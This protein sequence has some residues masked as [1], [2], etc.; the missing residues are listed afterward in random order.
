MPIRMTG[1]ISGLDTDAVVKELMSAQSLKKTKIEQKK[2]KAEWKQDKWKELNTKLYALY[3][4][5]VSK[6]KLKSSYMTKKVTSS[7]ENLVTATANTS[8][9]AGSHTIKVTELAS[10]QYLTGK[11]T[12]GLK[13]ATANT[14]LVSESLG[15]KSGTIITV[16]VGDKSSSMTVTE[17]STIA[18][19]VSHLQSVGLNA[20]FDTQQDRFFIS[21]KESGLE[22]VFTISTSVI[23]AES[24]LGKARAELASALGE[25]A[26]ALDSFYDNYK[27][28]LDELKEKEKAVEN[29]T[30][31]DSKLVASN[32]LLTVKDKVKKLEDD[33][34]ALAKSSAEKAETEKAKE[35]V[36]KAYVK[37]LNKAAEDAK[38]DETVKDT[39][40]YK[41]YVE[42]K[43]AVDE[44]YYKKDDAGELT[45]EFSDAILT[46]A[47]AAYMADAK[48]AVE[49]DMKEN[50]TVYESTAQKE[51]AIEA[52]YKELTGSSEEAEKSAL[53]KKAE[54][55]YKDSLKS[56]LDNRGAVYAASDKA[57]AEVDALLID[58][59]TDNGETTS[60][61]AVTDRVE[62]AVEKYK[63]LLINPDES[64]V[65]TT[66]DSDVSELSFLG[67]AE[68]TKTVD[69][70]TGEVNVISSDGD[71]ILKQAK[72][73]IIELDG[74]ELKGTSN[75]F[76]AAG[77]T[78]DLKGT[79]AVGTTV[80]LNVS[81]DVDAVYDS[82]KDFFKEYNNLLK[83]MNTLYNATSARGYEPLTDEEK[84][85]M[86]DDQIKLWEDKIK[87]SLLRRD[88]TLGNLMSAMKSA[89]QS[90]VEVDGK[91]Y[92]LSYFGIMTSS[93]W[94]EGGLLHIYGDADD[95]TYS[96]NEDKLKAAL[97]SEPD[98]V[99]EALSG[100]ITKLSETMADKMKKTSLSSA[101]TFYNDKQ[102]KDNIK[103][104][105]DDI[106]KWE[107]RLKDIE[108][109]YYK[110]FSAMESA[111]AK[112]QSQSGY[113]GNLMGTGQ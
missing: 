56:A 102:I 18:D 38:T 21:S 108:D 1:M 113:L 105:E 6:L 65:Q 64:G 62:T 53:N 9:A 27:V 111:M 81:N 101:L 89:M 70:A 84:E 33:L 57:K 43:K 17:N 59:D 47:K 7:N 5:K 112:L 52:K 3:T 46:K 66:G 22:N 106:K 41:A 107:D 24:E 35:A 20:T 44:T 36:A 60:V 14:K 88:S 49:K 76:T 75:T 73:A 50:G 51:E 83:E 94:T 48:A 16:N 15:M 96:S 63:G 93:A 104:Y 67:L 37:R 103:D 40:D 32:E 95:S 77:V 61:K 78:F 97:A 26:S 8:A 82:I 39:E 45:E 19:F 11:T 109:R 2:T 54:E 110:Q 80:T 34:V 31:A 28:A 71:V 13:N 4:E 30:D 68:L 42:V 98:V 85:A 92:S 87:D 72:N 10:A 74:A 12:E 25:N 23:E 58:G 99:M 91:K 29:A 90:N 100:I 55:L 69:E 79:T 86:S